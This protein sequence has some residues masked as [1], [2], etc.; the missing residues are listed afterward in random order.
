MSKEEIDLFSEYAEKKAD[1]I[2]ACYSVA[3]SQMSNT[4]A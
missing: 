1:G 2:Y 4:A 3:I